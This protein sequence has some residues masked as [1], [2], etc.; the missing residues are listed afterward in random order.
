MKTKFNN[1]SMSKHNKSDLMNTSNIESTDRKMR[2][3]RKMVEIVKIENVVNEKVEELLGKEIHNN[4]NEIVPINQALS[5]VKLIGLFFCSVWASPCKL[6]SNELIDLYN[7]TNQGVKNLEIIQ[8]TLEKDHLPGDCNKD[9]NE[10]IRKE[11]ENIFKSKIQD[12]PWLFYQFNNENCRSLKE[13]FN[14]KNVPQ[15]IILD[16]YCNIITKDG[17]KDYFQYGPDIG[18]KW[19]ENN[20]NK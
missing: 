13:K 18:E 2:S 16:E 5:N 15:L 9:E 14:V 7:E 3:S 11:G 4:M 10:R 17:I 20:K 12:F 8:I 19:M 6:I 1:E